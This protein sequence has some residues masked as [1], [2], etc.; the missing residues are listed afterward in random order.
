MKLDPISNRARFFLFRCNGKYNRSSG[1]R[2]FCFT[3]ARCMLCKLCESVFALGCC[4]S[5]G[6]E[7]VNSTSLVRRL[8]LSKLKLPIPVSFL[9]SLQCRP[10]RFRLKRERNK[11]LIQVNL[12]NFAGRRKG[13]LSI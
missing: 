7:G 11:I 13:G 1:S 9:S 2:V 5:C 12:D 10:W 6:V 4:R 8:L 3:F